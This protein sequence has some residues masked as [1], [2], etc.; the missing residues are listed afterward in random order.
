MKPP[1]RKQRPS[2]L[3]SAQRSGHKRIAQFGYRRSR[4]PVTLAPVALQP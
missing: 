3:K 4:K 1:K 2:Y